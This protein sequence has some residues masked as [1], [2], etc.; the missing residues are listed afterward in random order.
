MEIPEIHIPDVHIP[1]TYVPDYG[2]STFVG[3]AASTAAMLFAADLGTD[4]SANATSGL[5]SNPGTLYL[6][7][8]GGGAYGSPRGGYGGGGIGGVSSGNT[9]GRSHGLDNSGSGGGGANSVGMNGGT[10]VVVV[11]YVI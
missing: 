1:Y 5:S 10:G 9:S 7:G 4:G 8:G 6:A 2:H 3:D 11:R